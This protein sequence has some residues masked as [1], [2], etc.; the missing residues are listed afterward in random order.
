MAKD[1]EFPMK[2]SVDEDDNEFYEVSPGLPLMIDLSKTTFIIQHP[3]EDGGEA[4]LILKRRDISELVLE[5]I[6]RAEEHFTST[7]GYLGYGYFLTNWKSRNLPHGVQSRKAI[8]DSLIH[9]GK[10]EVYIADDGK[11]AIR[12]VS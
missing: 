9:E 2:V 7:G 12:H 3:E 10:I 8:V 5:E 6:Q 11:E 4:T 1:I